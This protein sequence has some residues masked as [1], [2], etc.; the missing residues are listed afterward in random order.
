[1]IVASS[2]ESRPRL[3]GYRSEVAFQIAT[4]LIVSVTIGI[5]VVVDPRHLG[6]VTFAMAMAIFGTATVLAFVL[7]RTDTSWLFVVPLLDMIALI[8][9]R[10][11]PE[12]HVHAIAYLA[13]LPALWLGWSGRLPFAVLAMVFSFGLIEIPGL[14]GGEPLDLEHALR[15]FLVPAVVTAAALSTY[16]AS[17]RTQFIIQSLVSQE[18]RA[19]EALRQ[20]QQ[21]SKLLDAIVDAVDTV[22]L[23]FDSDRNQLLANQRAK[24]HPSIIEAGVAGLDLEAAGLLYE[25]D[26][27]TPIPAEDGIIGRALQ[28]EEFGDRIAWVGSPDKRQYAVS[29]SARALYDAEGN[30]AGTVIAMNDVTSY[31]E[32]IAAKDDFVASV[33]HEL[34]TPLASIVG[35]LELIEDD[36]G[37]VPENV[38]KHLSVI[39]RNTQRLQRL[40][41]DLLATASEDDQDMKIE[42]RPRD[43]RQLCEV[44]L[45]GFAKAARN[46]QVRLHLHAPDAAPAMVDEARMRQAIGNLVSN[47]IKFSPAGTVVVTVSAVD[48]SVVV[49]IA[50]TGV[51][52][53]AGEL[54]AIMSRFYRAT[55]VREHFPGMGLGL[56]VSRAII[57][58]HDGSIDIASEDERGTTVT[59]TL[60]A[61]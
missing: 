14:N 4:L 11:I 52:V 55:T 56:S 2:V 19:A 18:K 27:V 22:V 29:A 21:A 20:Q 26:R 28:G 49:S 31:L 57:E 5:S 48:G 24:N 45:E 38:R 42:R 23:A 34:R 33:S 61:P 53:P 47:S 39:D 50:V 54:E 13:I 16:L 8:V 51:G 32:I 59:V 40:I 41:T 17:S 30:F 25:L 6:T 10:Q 35:Y 7:G 1:M 3:F 43:I 46:S 58:A 37:D 9:M 44:V 36:E 60:P 15:N 12:H